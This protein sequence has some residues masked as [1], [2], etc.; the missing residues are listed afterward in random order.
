MRP[1]MTLLVSPSSVQPSDD[2]AMRCGRLLGLSPNWRKLSTELRKLTARAL[3]EEPPVS[4]AS[5]GT[6]LMSLA[7]SF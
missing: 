7:E 4:A 3:S 5:S 1:Q 6:L 2:Y